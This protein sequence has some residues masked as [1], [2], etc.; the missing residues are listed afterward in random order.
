MEFFIGD[1]RLVG[2]LYTPASDA[3]GVAVITGPLTSVKEQAPGAYAAA[4]AKQ[5]IAALAFDHRHFGESGGSPRQLEDPGQKIAD[6][7]AAV[8]AVADRY[9][10]LPVYAVGVCAGAGYMAAAVAQ[11][12]RFAAFG[13]VAGFY[14]D[15]AQSRDWMGEGY[16]AAIAAGRQARL[17]FEAGSDAQMIPAVAMDGDRA[18]P[19]DEAFD[20]Y[21]TDRGGEARFPNYTNAFAVMSREVTTPFDAQGAADKITVPTLMIH[22]ENALS[23]MLARRFFDKLGGPKEQD[24]LQSKGQ[25]DFYDDPSLI[26]P[27]VTMLS[28]FFRRS[29]PA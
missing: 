10:V 9:P 8:D 21:G 6:I 19:M 13:G 28:D 4:L 17:D 18:M 2:D 1:D 5:G 14:H 24:W 16:D 25:I 23:P 27:A 29:L 22:S 11:E 12:P 20:Y 15:A 7:R 3:I 26:A